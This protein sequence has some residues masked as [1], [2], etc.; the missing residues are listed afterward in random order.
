[1][2]NSILTRPITLPSFL[3]CL[4]VSAVLGILTALVFSYKNRHSA[5]LSLALAILPMAVCMVIMLVNGNIGTGV[6]IAGAFALVRFR[7][8]PGTAREIAA[9]F[10]AMALGLATGMGYVGLAAVFFLVV[11]VLVLILT[12]VRFGESP[13]TEKRLKITIP[14]NLNYDSLFDDLFQQYGLRAELVQVKTVS[15]GTL[16]ELTYQVVFSAP[17]VPKAFLDALRTRNG[18]LTIAVT[19]AYDREML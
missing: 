5:S 7:S 18:N 16:F 2:L 4:I 10:I 3:I 17:S 8:T 1:M 15:M 14:E 13:R 19:S 6:A 12:A 11:A 9:I